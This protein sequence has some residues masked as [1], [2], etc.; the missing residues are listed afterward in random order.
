M[1]QGRGPLTAL[2]A[3]DAE[4]NVDDSDDELQRLV[5]DEVEGTGFRRG[6]TTVSTTCYRFICRGDDNML[7]IGV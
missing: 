7:S 2:V 3:L 5:I 1:N 6:S 4:I